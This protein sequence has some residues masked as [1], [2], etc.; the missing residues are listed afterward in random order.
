MKEYNV[1]NFVFAS[2]AIVYGASQKL[3]MDENTPTDCEQITNAYGRTK[4]IAEQILKDLYKS[5][6]VI[7]I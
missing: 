3:P 7:L 6:K 5:D 1:K 2:S 4:Y